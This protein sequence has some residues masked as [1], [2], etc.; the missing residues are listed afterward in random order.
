MD[1]RL[2][3]S[4]SDGTDSNIGIIE[5]QTVET[6]GDE[7]QADSTLPSSLINSLSVHESKSCRALQFEKSG[8]HLFTAGA[9]GILACLDIETQQI[10]QSSKRNF[11]I[12]KHGGHGYHAINCLQILPDST[13][14]GRELIVTGDDFGSVL[15]W[16]LRKKSS[17]V[18]QWACHRDYVSGI[19]HGEDDGNIIL[20][21]S[22]D[23]T[24]C[25]LDVRQS[26]SYFGRLSS[27]PLQSSQLTMDD[28]DDDETRK[29]KRRQQKTCGIIGQSDDVED[30]LLSIQ[31]MKGGKKVVCGT[32]EG[33]ITI[34]SWGKWGDMSDRITGHPKSVDA[35]L[36]IDEDTILTGSID[37]VLRLVQIH[38]NKFLGVLGDHNGYPIEEL[39]FSHDKRL[40][41]SLS[42]D[43]LIRLWDASILNESDSESDCEDESKH[44]VSYPAVD[45][46]TKQ[47][48]GSEDEWEDEDENLPEPSD[49]SE[50]DTSDDDKCKDLISDSG[51]TS[52]RF[53]T[54]NE[55]FFED[56]E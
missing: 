8:N 17:V 24:L 19:E 55:R 2:S 14:G 56:L 40:I 22:G 39:K 46:P 7:D 33:T 11:I 1:S 12:S 48:D 15:L 29:R 41:G 34:W 52:K 36:K 51:K 25:A 47:A 30:E 4:E 6:S 10:C 31:I 43:N 49:D 54:E 42:H 32:N 27:E 18:A 28:G 50:D 45:L 53:K 35:L 13:L 38:P 3:D 9:D 5:Q 26:M 23:C 44:A 21:T 16:D 20:T 37:G